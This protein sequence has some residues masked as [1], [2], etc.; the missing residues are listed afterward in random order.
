MYNKIHQLRPAVVALRK[1]FAAEGVTLSH[2]ELLHLAAQ[3][4]GAS[5]WNRVP[6]E[7]RRSRLSKWWAPGWRRSPI[8][9]IDE[10]LYDINPDSLRIGVAGKE[11]T[12]SVEIPVSLLVR[13]TLIVGQNGW[14][15]TTV[16]EHLCA[17]QLLRKAGL[18]VLDTSP[19]EPSARVIGSAAEACGRQDYCYYDHSASGSER[20]DDVASLVEQGAG[21]YVTLPWGIGSDGEAQAMFE[22]FALQLERVGK[23]RARNRQA[24]N[25]SG[26]PVDWPFMIYVA[27]DSRLFTKSWHSLIE[28]ARVYNFA[29]VVRVHSLNELAELPPAVA[30]ALY[31]L[32]TKVFYRPNSPAS[33]ELAARTLELSQT[34][35]KL[36]SVSSQ[37]AEL[38]FGDALYNHY[39]GPRKVLTGMF[40]PKVRFPEDDE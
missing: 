19:N 14:G 17:Q 28:L 10:L 23:E 6:R 26:S 31:S 16:M 40:V 9:H 36:H 21:A 11:Q 27:Y 25:K 15:A 4:H 2:V 20:L 24:A 35:E 29:L 12:T 5:T 30:S 22:R 8:V 33:L 32:H 3:A 7:A 38:G 39:T 37:L 18:L 1:R 34:A 13:G